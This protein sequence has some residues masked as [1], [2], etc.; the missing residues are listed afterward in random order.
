MNP[1]QRRIVFS[2]GINP[3]RLGPRV[4]DHPVHRSAGGE[5]NGAQRS[6]KDGKKPEEVERD[7]F[8]DVRVHGGEEAESGR[9]RGRKAMGEKEKE[10]GHPTNPQR[11][12]GGSIDP[13]CR[14]PPAWNTPL[15]LRLLFCSLSLPPSASTLLPLSILPAF[16]SHCS[17]SSSSERSPTPFLPQL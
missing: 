5:E 12:G 16:L 11:S 1:P 3:R 6:R 13:E 7:R 14:R 2:R 17:S 8:T 15:L 9:E 10:P 4:L